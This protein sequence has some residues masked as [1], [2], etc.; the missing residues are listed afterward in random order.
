MTDRR[1]TFH[2]AV[3]HDLDEIVAYYGERDPAL[4]RRFRAR[5]SQQVERIERF[6]RSGTILFDAYRRVRLQRFP[7]MAVY[8]VGDDGL[9]LLAA[10]HVRRDPAFIE[11]AVCGRA[12]R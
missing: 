8:L 12:D 1:L 11:E 9:D 5:L 4:P 7:Y 10:V 2:P 6:P 3:E